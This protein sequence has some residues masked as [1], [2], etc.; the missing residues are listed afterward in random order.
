MAEKA[1]ELTIVMRLRNLMKAQLAKAGKQIQQQIS[2]IQKY[3]NEIRAT[4]KAAVAVALVGATLF[5]ASIVQAA[6]FEKQMSAVSAITKAN[7]EDQKLLR[8][9][10]IEQGSKSVFSASQ[11]AKAQELLGQSGQK[12]REIIASLPSVLEL[13]AAGQTDLAFAAELSASTLK[14]FSLDAEESSRVSNVL[15]ASSSTS[16]ATLEKLGFAL[17]QAGPDAA[18]FDQSLEGTV[19]TISSFIDLGLR[20][21]QAGTVFR[22]ALVG[23]AKPSSEAQEILDR[24]GVQIFDTSGKMLPFVDVVEQLEKASL[25]TIDAVTIFG[26][27]AGGKMAKLVNKGADAL[28]EMEKNVTGTDEAAR[29]AKVRTDNLAGSITFLKS[30]IE[31]A[32]ISVGSEY[33]PA[34]RLAT[35]ILTGFVSEFNSL[36]PAMKSLLANLALGATA[37]L[38]FMGALGL[39]VTALAVTKISLFVIGAGL[40]AILLLLAKG[41]LVVGVFIA[42]FKLT[43]MLLDLDNAKL[44]VLDFF[45][46]FEEGW[47]RLKLVTNTVVAF[48]VSRLKSVFQTLRSTVLKPLD[49]IFEAAKKLKKSIDTNPFDA[50][51]QGLNGLESHTSEVVTNIQTE[52]SQVNAKYEDMRDAVINASV[53]QE[54][55]K[56]ATDKTNQA[57]ATQDKKI[58]DEVA[59]LE[60][61]AEKAK[62]LAADIENAFEL[63]G[64]VSTADSVAEMDKLISATG[65][66][67]ESGDL[68][69]E[70]ERDLISI[71]GEKANAITGV[72]S[73]ME[74]LTSAVGQYSSALDGLLAVQLN[75]LQG[76]LEKNLAGIIDPT[77]L[78]KNAQEAEKILFAF[79]NSKEGKN[80]EELREIEDGSIFNK[81]ALEDFRKR[82]DAGE[83]VFLSAKQ[84]NEGLV[85]SVRNA[86]ESYANLSFAIGTTEGKINDINAVTATHREQL[87]G[88]FRAPITSLETLIGKL[89]EEGASIQQISNAE[90]LLRDKQASFL[91]SVIAAE[92]TKFNT[93]KRL[94]DENLKDLEENAKKIQGIE[95]SRADNA[96]AIK[97]IDELRAN[98]GVSAEEIRRRQGLNLQG[99]IF[100]ARGLTGENKADALRQIA[101]KGEELARAS[102]AGGNEFNRFLQIAKT[103]RVELD[104]VQKLLGDLARNNGIEADAE[105]SKNAVAIMEESIDGFQSKLRVLETEIA[106]S[107]LMLSVDI[108]DNATGP[109]TELRNELQDLFKQPLIQE[110]IVKQTAQIA[111]GGFGK[112]DTFFDDGVEFQASSS[113]TTGFGSGVVS[114]PPKVTPKVPESFAKGIKFIP[115]D[116]LVKVHKGESILTRSESDQVRSGGRGGR[117]V[118]FT[119]NIIVQTAPGQDVTEETARILRDKINKL[120]DMDKG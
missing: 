52:L 112:R 118:T 76:D 73:R 115:K 120:D 2:N 55:L 59:V 94:R 107:N 84:D 57:I 46:V 93:L 41:A 72:T 39:L 85:A 119:G 48:M 110:V 106:S 79:S 16:L 32:S 64:L 86:S 113:D 11:A 68:T 95:K 92:E 33:I 15:A 35:D 83:A 6:S 103:A 54:V 4:S 58:D 81:D 45:E 61:V 36:D 31:G 69:I 80:G 114:A 13:A 98:A 34:I 109:G 91:K 3:Q 42:A 9:A 27:E 117:N 116:T 7:V 47:V 70:Q 12:T 20:G 14:Q 50:I 78:K 63:T 60:K 1:A 67:L 26:T 38:G 10:A 62:A 19:A 40:G 74:T 90:N 66:L 37:V 44:S 101:E 71:F 43:Q 77:T 28:R 18:A 17:R 21:E 108:L 53:A 82:R 5:T 49:L 75:G 99:D 104:G 56:D 22:A 30:A 89:K 8:N 25:S 29:Q 96:E 51:D 111:S 97:R 88:L 105:R 24:L 100:K 102:S 65:L 87:D 23:L